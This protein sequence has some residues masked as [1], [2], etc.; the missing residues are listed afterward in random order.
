MQHLYSMVLTQVGMRYCP[1]TPIR[2]LELLYRAPHCALEDT[3]LWPQVGLLLPTCAV[4]LLCR[5]SLEGRQLPLK[6][7]SFVHKM[8]PWLRVLL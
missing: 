8:Q 3:T 1:V 2:F 6:L 4:I 5:E 7:H